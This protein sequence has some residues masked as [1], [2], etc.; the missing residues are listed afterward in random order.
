[1]P[2]ALVANRFNLDGYNTGTA[3]A[4]TITNPTAIAVGSLL[5]IRIHV[6]AGATATSITDPR[7]NSW[8]L[9]GPAHNGNNDWRFYIAYCIVSNPYQ[10]G[11]SVTINASYGTSKIASMDEFSGIELSSPEDVIVFEYDGPNVGEWSAT[12]PALTGA[13]HLLVGGMAVHSDD[14]AYTP[15]TPP[16]WTALSSQTTW[17]DF[18]GRRNL[19]GHYAVHS[20][21]GSPTYSGG[22]S[23]FQSCAIGVIA[24]KA[25]LISGKTQTVVVS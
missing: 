19:I 20:T 18:Q 13:S 22:I 11:D 6:T 17:E 25:R 7:G 23:Q 1:M 9:R 16:P 14:R 5:T 15:Y 4:C 2:P 21:G 10:G 8:T 12:L 24:F 3:W